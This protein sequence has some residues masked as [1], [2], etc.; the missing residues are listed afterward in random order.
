MMLACN[1]SIL[2]LNEY[3]KNAEEKEKNLKPL[4]PNMFMGIEEE[5]R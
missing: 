1:K 5:S 3:I 2:R 4:S